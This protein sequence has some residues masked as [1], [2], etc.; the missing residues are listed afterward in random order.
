MGSHV[1]AHAS[2]ASRDKDPDARGGAAVSLEELL[3]PAGAAMGS[4]R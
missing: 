3:G 2:A 4:G 1:L